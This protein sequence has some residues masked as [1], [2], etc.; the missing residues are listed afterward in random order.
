MPE[1]AHSRRLFPYA[2]GFVWQPQLRAML[3]AA[4]YSL[5]LG[6]PG[7]EDRVV[8]WGRSPYAARGE[9][10]AA[11]RGVGL[12][13]LEDAFLRSVRPGRARGAGGPLGLFIDPFGVHFDAATPS[14]LERL[15]A[16]EP[17]DDT[18]LLD[19][20]RDGIARLK[21]LQLSKYND[22]DETL[23][24]PAPGYVLVIDQIRGDASIAHG[25]ATAASFREMLAVAQIENP[26]ARIV[27][28]T[29]PET[30]AGLRPGHYG[31]AQE[32]ARTT[33]LT[34]PVAPWA[35]LDGAIAVY[36]VSS[37]LGYE[38]I[39]AGHRPRVFGQPFYAGWG[40]SVDEN[41][42]PRRH[43]RLTRAQI[44]AVSHILAPTWV[45]PC[46]GRICRFEE[47]VDQLEAEVRAFRADRA[48]HVAT[49]MRLW[50][51]RP[52]QQFFGREK[53]LRF[54]DPPDRAAAVAQASGRSLLLWAGKE[55]PGFGPPALRVEDGFLRSKG[56]GADL[57]PPL[58]LVTDARGIYFDPT[59]P[60]DLEDLI[61]RP[62]PPGG[63][64]RAERL[65]AALRRDK[66]SKYNLDGRTPDLPQGYRILVPGQV[67]DDASIRLGAGKTCTNLALLAQTR[68]LNPKAIILFKPHPDVEAGLRPGALPEAEALRHADLVLHKSNPVALIEA[69]DEVWTMTSLLG[70]EALLRGKKV[71]VTGAPFYAGWGLTR[72]LGPV[73]DRRKAR[74]TLAQMVHAALIAYP[75]YLDPVT[76]RP[77]PPEVVIDRL[78]HGPLPRPGPLNRSLAKL[79]GLFAGVAFLWR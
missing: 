31:P 16:R 5:H 11:R 36:T 49:G 79:Q 52:L 10:V 67:E 53:P 75:R 3:R 47:A 1:A 69:V 29:H 34:D 64:A 76:R 4:G 6:L 7:P 44:F 63:L 28:K 18:A 46:R 12:V 22:F 42:V 27:I 17:L 24:P 32:D 8:V 70:F 23:P 37:L 57:V 77:C 68:A 39:L 41:P 59:R 48:G 73:P 30:R 9:A 55:P 21:A 25:G 14:L 74:P 13:R 40:L 62:P 38:A 26:G 51:R 33:L 78:A 50:K 35:L 65:I 43:R 58:S 19:R 56:L 60:S 66:V 45:D 54:V 2:A 61:S 72:D 20:A 71:T 15:L